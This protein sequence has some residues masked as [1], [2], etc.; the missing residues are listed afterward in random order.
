M[1]GA[2]PLPPP[3]EPE[4]AAARRLPDEV[5]ADRATQLDLVSDLEDIGEIGRNLAVL[6]PLD[7]DR[8]AT[9]VLWRAIE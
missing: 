2:T 9:A 3:I 7:G 8:H 1:S 6:Q 5:A 4:R